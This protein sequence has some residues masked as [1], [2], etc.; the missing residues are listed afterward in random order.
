MRAGTS[1]ARRAMGGCWFGILASRGIVERLCNPSATERI[2][3]G[4]L[5]A[6]TGELN[7]QAQIQCD[8]DTINCKGY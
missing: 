8:A 2:N 4:V 6:P 7:L 3:D 1:A 5:S